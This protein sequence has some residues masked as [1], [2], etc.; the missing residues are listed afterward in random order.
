MS[1]IVVTG[2]AGFIGSYL[3]DGL[4]REGYKVIIVD[5]LKRGSALF[6]IHPAAIFIQKD[7]LDLSL[8]QDLNA[9]DI[10]GIYHLAAQTS[11]EGS[12][13][14]PSADIL[15][16]SYGTYLLA[17]YCRERKIQRLIYSS[18]S[19]IYGIACKD[20]V[21]E[22]TIPE[23]NSIY[24]V[25]KYSGELFVR[26]LA[27]D[28]DTNYTIF[29]F[30]NI[31]G[32]G[33][34]LNYLGKGMVGIFCSFVWKQE[35]ILVRGSLDRF[36]DFLY[37]EDLV[38]AL[39]LSYDHPKAIN[40][41]YVA[42]SGK[43]VYLHEL[44]PAILVAAGESVDYP[45]IVGEGTPGDAHGFHSNIDKITTELGW[46]PRTDLEE[47]LRRFFDWI[48]EVPVQNDITSYHPLRNK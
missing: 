10:H 46:S 12:Y 32:P 9:Y 38:N 43:K 25:S 16:N 7:I 30:T 18:T 17:R 8:Y 34:N 4:L 47:G 45:V 20:A 29:R 1:H 41:I 3:V 2:G 37:V 35:P 6:Y 19:A 31:Y 39:I 27:H 44:I 22:T 36:R 5:D 23:P 13:Q 48:H 11:T 15:T 24:G 14:D 42:S 40:Q 21:D 28:S 33:E 26:Q